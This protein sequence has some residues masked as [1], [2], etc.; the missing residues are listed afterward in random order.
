MLCGLVIGL[1]MEVFALVRQIS[2]LDERVAPMGALM[3]DESPT[4]GDLAPV[5]YLATLAGPRVQIGAPGRAVRWCS[6]IAPTC[7]MGKKLISVLRSSAKVES[8]WC[9]PATATKRAARLVAVT[10]ERPED[11]ALALDSWA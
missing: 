4:V 9:W 6:F 1:A 3:M 7:S 8:A 10:R 11:R 2:V 5:F